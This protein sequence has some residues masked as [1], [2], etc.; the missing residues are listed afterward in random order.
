MSLETKEPLLSTFVPAKVSG[1]FRWKRTLNSCLENDARESLVV[2][3]CAPYKILHASSRWCSLAGYVAADLV[4]SSI[5][6]LRGPGTE[7][8]EFNNILSCIARSEKHSSTLV[9]Y[10]N[11]GRPFVTHCHVAPSPH[12]RASTCTLY[13]SYADTLRM[14]TALEDEAGWLLVNAETSNFVVIGCSSVAAQ[15]FNSAPENLEGQL[16][17]IFYGPTTDEKALRDLIS[18]CLAGLPIANKS[19]SGLCEGFLRLD[20]YRA[21]GQRLPCLLSAQAVLGEGDGIVAHVKLRVVRVFGR[22]VQ[23]NLQ[24]ARQDDPAGPLCHAIVQSRIYV[25]HGGP[26]DDGGVPLDMAAAS[27]RRVVA[28]HESWYSP[29][30]DDFGPPCLS[31]IADFICHLDRE[32]S[33][34]GPAGAAIIWVKPSRRAVTNALFLAGAY[35]VLRLGE[36]AAAVSQRL[37]GLEGHT[38]AYRDASF[39]PPA[40]GLSLPDCWQALERARDRV[41]VTLQRCVH[42]GVVRRV[43]ADDVDD[44]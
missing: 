24:S 27:A 43:V 12:S 18:G 33:A 8:Q 32:L 14:N 42:D 1:I 21:G 3:K 41:D 25:A 31:A 35:A 37:D 16:L 26:E 10:R 29:L 30:C 15:L 4:G 5:D 13:L 38:E 9:T 44:R 36:T 40:F 22:G 2:E 23:I 11:G 17:Q 6:I 20:L 28:A 19:D 34:A 39:A 7:A